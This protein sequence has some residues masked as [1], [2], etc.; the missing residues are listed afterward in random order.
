MQTVGF[1]NLK[2]WGYSMRIRWNPLRSHFPATML[3]ILSLLVIVL[4]IL[5]A[6]GTNTGGTPSTGDFARPSATL[7]RAPTRAALGSGELPPAPTL[8]GKFVFAPGDG[9]I[10]VQDPANGKPA[11]VVKPSAELFADS[12][13]WSPDG[14]TFV[15]VHSALTADGTAQ[16]AIYRANADG[17]ENVMVATPKNKKTTF[18]WPH[19]SWDGKWVYYTASTPVPP[20]KQDSEIQRISVDGGEPQTIVSEAR[21]STESPDGKHIAYLR[22][23]FETFTAALW[24]ADLDGQNARELVSKEVFILIS[25]PRFSP[26]GSQIMFS[27]SGPNTRPLPGVS[28][29]TRDWNNQ[30]CTPQLLCMFA[31]PAHA[32]GLPWDLWTVTPDGS[33]FTRLTKIGAD[34]PWPAWSKDSKMVAFMDTSGQYVIDLA[35]QAVSQL[36]RS[37]GHGVFD[38]WQP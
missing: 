3:R 4:V 18:N 33:K 1:A 30:D 8:S 25:S 11:P 7:E 17:T 2:F 36:T 14:K 15:Y 12:P 35:T 29:R 26:D 24:I 27:A 37:G 20:N 16:N 32:D 34:S 10:W 31:Q 6:C 21:M 23:D 19:Y 13:N 22:F 9:S 38:W 28:M 5:T